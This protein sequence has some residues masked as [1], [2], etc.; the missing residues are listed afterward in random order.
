[1]NRG[2]SRVVEYV[3]FIVRQNAEYASQLSFG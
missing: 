3:R 1:M 2:F